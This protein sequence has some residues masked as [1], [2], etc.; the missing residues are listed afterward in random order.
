MDKLVNELLLAIYKAHTHHLR[1]ASTVDH[2]TVDWTSPLSLVR[3]YVAKIKTS[4][5]DAV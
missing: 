3:G 1:G 5:P 2:A 4:L